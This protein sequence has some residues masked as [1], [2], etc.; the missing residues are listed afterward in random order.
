MTL[1]ITFFVVYFLMFTLAIFYRPK[2]SLQIAKRRLQKDYSI[3]GISEDLL[4]YF[5][6][7]EFTFPTIFK[8]AADVYLQNGIELHSTSVNSFSFNYSQHVASNANTVKPG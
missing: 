7:L 3:V 4:G 1:T 5:Q 6:L 2:L 8:G